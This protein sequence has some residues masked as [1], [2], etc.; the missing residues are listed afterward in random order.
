MAYASTDDL[1]TYGALPAATCALFTTAQKTAALEEASALADSYLAGQT[2]GLPLT[3][4]G[5]DLRAGVCR[6]AAWK[7]LQGLRGYDAAGAGNAYKTGRDEVVA[8]LKDVAAGKA[9][10]SGGG[11][12][13][14]PTQTTGARVSTRESRGWYE[15]ATETEDP[16]EW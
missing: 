6:I 9:K 12:N 1:D 2:Q 7:L 14:A 3:T 10:V 8:W 11:S 5:V 13:T 16:D 15:G 4:W